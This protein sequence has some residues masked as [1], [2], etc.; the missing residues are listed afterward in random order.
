M[1]LC[2]GA[3]KI[4][5]FSLFLLL[6][7]AYLLGT[8]TLVH[9]EPQEAAKAMDQEAR[10]GLGLMQAVQVTLYQ[11]PEVLI[12]QQEV[13]SSRGNLRMEAGMFDPNFTS[14]FL[15]QTNEYAS[16]YW[17]QELYGIGDRNFTSTGSTVGLET[18]SRYGFS[19]GPSL[20]VTR[21]H[22]ITDYLMPTSYNQT[23]VAFSVNVPLLK[24]MGKE[25]ADAKEMAA[26][27]ELEAS[28]LD[29][30][31][32]ISQSV[33]NTTQ[34]Y[35]GYLSALRQFE[36]FREMETDAGQTLDA[37]RELVKGDERPASDLDPFEANLAQKTS[38]RINSEQTLFEAKQNLGLAMG[39]AYTAIDDLPLPKDAFPDTVSGGGI[40]NI[41]NPD[42]LFQEAL[43]KRPDF[44]ALKKREN[45][46]KIILTAAKNNVL[47]QLDINAGVG[48]AGL[49]NGGE[50]SDYLK[51]LGK[52]VTG[53]NYQAGIQF[54]YPFGNNEAEGLVVQRR[55]NVQMVVIRTRDLARKINSGILVAVQAL[56][57]T[58]RELRETRNS[59]AHYR[60]AV[61]SEQIKF[62]MG[63]AS[64][65]DVINMQDRLRDVRL[66][67][68]T[69][70]NRFADAVVRLG[71]ETGTL[72]MAEGDTY[73]IEM[74]NL[75]SP[76]STKGTG[77]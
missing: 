35:W 21:S 67:E 24:G 5:F 31:Q 77:R 48:Y 27:E 13:E 76:W 47:P 61:S 65:M 72:V 10:A 41:M 44:L 52:N 32:T 28:T 43:R 40:S 70:M 12:Q 23:I 17:Q 54:S 14:S 34:A 39:L 25:A 42:A 46:A 6:T 71:F 62:S 53:A 37:I 9:S 33:M 22:G 57:R 73:R 55:S 30:E 20:G 68:V 60:K 69:Q 74:K 56:W 63:M 15:Y 66:S 4:L 75:T 64:V 18:K 7:S 26:M 59:I 38:Q 8:S 49:E 50:V 1:T 36:V 2:Q 29:L 3:G 19:F 16:T 58:L 51:S 11:Q 45:A